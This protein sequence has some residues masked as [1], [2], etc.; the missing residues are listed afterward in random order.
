MI[1]NLTL[2]QALY[3]TSQFYGKYPKEDTS[4]AYGLLSIAQKRFN[5]KHRDKDIDLLIKSKTQK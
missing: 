3:I 5:E 2:E 1:P 4:Q